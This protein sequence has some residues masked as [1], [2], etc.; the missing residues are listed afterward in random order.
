[1]YYQNYSLFQI[2]L[3]YVTYLF[4][5]F[6][7]TTRNPKGKRSTEECEFEKPI[8]CDDGAKYR[9]YDGSCNN[10]KYPYWGKAETPLARFLKSDYHDGKQFIFCSYSY[11]GW[12]IMAILRQ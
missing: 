3:L 4:L 2:T 12:T 1:M 8:H 5:L 6:I 9:T 10:L 11:E 7:P